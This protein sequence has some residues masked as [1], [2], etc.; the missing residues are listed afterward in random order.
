MTRK[1]KNKTHLKGGVASAPGTAEG[2]PKSFVIKHGQVGRSLTQLVRDI[3]KVMEPN[4]AT[5]LRE[6]ARNK[7]KDFFTMAPPLGVTHILAFTLT[8]ISPS[9]RIVRLSAGPT[10][11][12]RVERYSLIKD[13]MRTS[14]RAKSIGSVEY[15]SPPL[16]VLAQFPPPGPDSPPHLSLVMKSFQTLFPPL[17]PQTLSLSSARRVVLVSYNKEKGTIDFRHFLISVRPYGVSK[18][19]QRVLDGVA[20]SSTATGILNLGS[21]KDVADFLLRKRGEPGPSTD[22]YESAA[23]TASSVAGDDGD[24]ISLADDY[25]GRNNKKGSKRAVRLDEIGPRMELR[26]IKISEGVPGKEGNVIHHEFVKKTKLQLK[27]Q[28]AEHAEKTKL[29]NQR[30]IEQEKNIE[31]KKKLAEQDE[32]GKGKAKAGKDDVEEEDDDDDE[33]ADE[34]EEDEMAWD[35]EEEITDGEEDDESAAE[36]SDADDSDDEPAQP[37][38][39]RRKS[40][41]Q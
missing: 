6:R 24:A 10:L 20:K 4:T 8:D 13:V 18:R 1:R 33:V 5:R 2:V 3:R 26:L 32:K 37:P 19:V 38:P 28:Q 23:S 9:F 29:R 34:E 25:V 36:G 27:A 30:R 7:L 16:L 11:S 31:R 39:K 15:L 22:G 40:S 41:K 21:E 12:F 35:E 17:A 14:K